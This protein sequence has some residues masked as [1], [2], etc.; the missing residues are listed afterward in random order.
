MVDAKDLLKWAAIGLAVLVLLRLALF[1][2]GVVV[3]AIIWAIQIAILLVVLGAIGFGV[4]WLYTTFIAD[5][6][7]AGSKSREKIYER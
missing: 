4:Y 7:T 6:S 1:L 5:S 3:S 2:F